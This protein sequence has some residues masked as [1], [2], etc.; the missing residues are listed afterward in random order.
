MTVYNY[1][2]GNLS[3]MAITVTNNWLNLAEVWLYNKGARISPTSLTFILSST[4][5]GC[6]ASGN[7]S[8]STYPCSASYCN[9]GLLNTICHSGTNV[10]SSTLTI[11]SRGM[12]AVD[13]ILIRNRQDCCQD[14]FNT[15]MLIAYG[16]VT[17]IWSTVVPITSS[18]S[19]E[20]SIGKN[21]YVLIKI[22]ANHLTKTSFVSLKTQ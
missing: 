18:L 19:Y 14:R 10:G 17:A 11:Q 16:N 20:F 21:V 15:A 3:S 6:D 1:V 12:I 9:D 22:I 2:G 8:T 4:M 5:S 13:Q 7:P